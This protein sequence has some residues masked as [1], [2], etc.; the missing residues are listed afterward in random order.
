MHAVSQ[1]KVRPGCGSGREG[2]T[3]SRSSHLPRLASPS[4]D[5]TG[6]ERHPQPACDELSDDRTRH[7]TYTYIYPIPKRNALTKTLHLPRSHRHRH[8]SHAARRRRKGSRTAHLRSRQ[9]PAPSHQD[10]A[11]CVVTGTLSQVRSGQDRT[12]S[13]GALTAR[14]C[15]AARNPTPLTPSP[16][17]L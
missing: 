16:P 8:P 5:W 7:D 4:P 13:L 11:G 12:H 1:E 17:L 15:S 14:A 9:P 10:R 2:V 3:V 6:L